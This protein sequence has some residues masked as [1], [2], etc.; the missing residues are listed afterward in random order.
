MSSIYDQLEPG[1]Q[2]KNAEQKIEQNENDSKKKVLGKGLSA[3]I[4]D[5]YKREDSH[6][7]EANKIVQTVAYKPGMVPGVQEI[8]L[9]EIEP[10]RD[11]PRM[12]FADD[13]LEEL[14]NSIQ[15]QGIVQPVIVRKTS[16]GYE[17]ICGER[18]IRAA[19]KCGLE[20]VPAIVKELAEEKLLEWALIE[21][22]QREDLN[23]I[24]EAQA[25]LRLDEERQLSHED[26]AKKVGKDRTTVVNTIRL[27]RLPKDVLG[28]LIEGQIQAGHARAILSLPTPELQMKLAQK[29][30]NEGL[31]VRQVE[32][33][34]SHQIKRKKK[35]K[36]SRTLT[37][38]LADLESRMEQRLG[39]QVRIYPGKNNQGK[40]EIQYY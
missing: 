25:Y 3:L 27:L 9:S 24:E 34:V 15:E 21:N 2:D 16:T 1:N 13:K 19:K 33:I 40:L 11:Q 23:P 39:T 28:F 20:K 37:P 22:I 10:N 7:D 6:I 29:I 17:A 18:R 36:R 30:V 12:T 32:E 38:E 31:T 5:L 26:I 4:S 8:P 14:A 35:G